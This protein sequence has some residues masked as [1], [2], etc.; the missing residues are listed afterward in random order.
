MQWG[1]VHKQQDVHEFWTCLCERLESELKTHPM[2]KLIESLFQGKQ[3]D[4]VTCRECGRTS[5]TEDVFQDLKLVVPLETPSS[6]SSS[7]AA[8]CTAT[9][10]TSTATAATDATAATASTASTAST[11]AFSSRSLSGTSGSPCTTEEVSSS[12]A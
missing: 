5:Y 12:P 6:S 3:R 8:T 11:S 10:A 9:A 2:H 4:F 1:S 7:A